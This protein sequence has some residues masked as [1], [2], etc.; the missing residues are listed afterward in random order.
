VYNGFTFQ[1]AKRDCVLITQ[2]C[3][4]HNSPEVVGSEPIP[5]SRLPWKEA[6]PHGV[7]SERLRGKMETIGI[8]T[9]ED[10]D[11]SNI[12][13]NKI[14]V[15][16]LIF[17]TSEGKRVYIG[18]TSKSFRRR[19][20]DHVC[21]LKQG[22]HNNARLQFAWNKYHLFEFKIIQICNTA[23]DCINAEQKWIEDLGGPKNL[24]NMG[25]ALPNP[26][27]GRTLSVEHKAKMSK[28][29]RGRP[30][31]NQGRI[32]SQEWRDAIG[33]GCK[34]KPAWNRGQHHSIK[35]LEKMSASQR[36]SHD[37]PD[38]LMR[39]AEHSER[40]KGQPAWNKGIPATEEAKKK[41]S[42]SR[43]GKKLVFSESHKKAISE[44]AKKRWENRTPEEKKQI[45]DKLNRRDGQNG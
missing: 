2:D 23:I 15:Y 38:G 30:G 19:L 27:F 29:L 21:R 44:V 41:M 18:S 35:T 26:M 3:A 34:G 22:N 7:G 39:A 43:T 42:I 31:P 24:L 40:L 37:S 8:V 12:P 36:K 20:S 10:F 32:L 25:P 45:L 11:Y 4:I 13:N 14:G 9:N 5:C 16:A 17:N 33:R 6:L 1:G 28:S